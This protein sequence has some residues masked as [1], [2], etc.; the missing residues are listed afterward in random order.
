MSK[1][2]GS[3]ELNSEKFVGNIWL[4]SLQF[5]KFS[6]IRVLSYY[7]LKKIFF[8]FCKALWK[9]FAESL[10]KIEKILIKFFENFQE[11]LRMF[12]N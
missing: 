10:K 8:N 4:I 6:V 5:E 3:L 2:L 11:I 12:K 1:I 9:S 7:N